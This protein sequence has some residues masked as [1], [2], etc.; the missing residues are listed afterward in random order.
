MA[1]MS[2]PVSV[3]V[4]AGVV[5]GVVAGIEAI[6]WMV[7]A[8]RGRN[9]KVIQCKGEPCKYHTQTSERVRACEVGLV[10]VV[11]LVDQGFRRLEGRI[12]RL[13]EAVSHK[14]TKTPSEMGE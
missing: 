8:M 14:K 4:T 7:P 2:D 13:T 12:D 3:G 11:S 5:A 9:G 6:K 10:N 1:D